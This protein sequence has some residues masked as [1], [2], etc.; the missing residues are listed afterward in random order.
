MPIESRRTFRLALTVTVALVLAYGSGMSVPYFAPLLAF[1]LTVKP[2]PPMPVGKLL[3]LAVA[4]AVIL[5][6]GL[7]V[8]PLVEQYAPVGLSLVA[9]GLF[10]SSRLSLG[11]DKAAV[12]TLLAMGLTLISALGVVSLALAQTLVMMLVAAVVIAVVSQWIVYP[13]FPESDLNP[14]VLPAAQDSA[15]GVSEDTSA[16]RAVVVILPAYLFLLINPTGHTPVMMKS[17]MLAQSPSVIEARQAA[18]ELLGATVLGGFLAVLL[19]FG[20][21]LSPRLDIFALLILWVMI[22]LGRKLYVSNST[23]FSQQFWIDVSVTMFILIGP[24]V[25]DSAAGKDPYQ[26]FLF[27]FGMF[28]L[29]AVYTWGSMVLLNRLG[30]LSKPHQELPA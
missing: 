6:I 22:G 16:L 10:V 26:A 9:L 12:G 14:E 30:W 4:L 27:R 5:G 13:F 29:V 3:I 2:A 17:I 7:W 28:F 20:L 21:K 23:R 18:M 19:W 8:A 15:E 24:A 1:I 11:G 25:A